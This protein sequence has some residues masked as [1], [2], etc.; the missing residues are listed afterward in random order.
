MQLREVNA[1]RSRA[2]APFLSVREN[3]DGGANLILWEPLEGKLNP[4]EG[5]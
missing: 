4:S 1:A 2:E 5:E 3:G